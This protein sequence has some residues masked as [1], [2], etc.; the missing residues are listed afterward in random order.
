MLPDVGRREGS[1]VKSVAARRR[2]GARQRALDV[3]V[4]KILTA[5]PGTVI[6]P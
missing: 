4:K 6:Q 2:L 3:Y 5:T 1:L